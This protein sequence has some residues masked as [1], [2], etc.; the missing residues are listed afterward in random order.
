MGVRRV[1][2]ETEW[3]G[4]EDTSGTCVLKTAVSF[5][6]ISQARSNPM[7]EIYSSRE[8]P[9]LLLFLCLKLKHGKQ[10]KGIFLNATYCPY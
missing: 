9:F 6:G 3:A 8:L 2:S 4:L 10:M 5:L 1:K 7:S